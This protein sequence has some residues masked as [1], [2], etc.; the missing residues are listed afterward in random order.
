M[1]SLKTSVVGAVLAGGESR[2]LGRDKALLPWLGK[3]LLLH[4]FEVLQ[5]VMSEV[6]V[7]TVGGRSYGELGVPVIHDR[8]EGLGPLAGIHAALEWARSRPVFVV[9]CDLPFVSV[10]LVE[11]VADWSTEQKPRASAGDEAWA[12]PRARVAVW[13]G[14]QQPLC[15]LYSASCREPLEERLRDGRLEAWRFLAEI[16][17]ASIPITHDLAFYRPDLLVNIN[18]PRDLQQGIPAVA[19]EVSSS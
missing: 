13:K 19:S 3:A 9:A 1:P 16:E 14:R 6:V 8:F 12:H 15:G 11:H 5:E 7:V 10:D 4:P 18:S 2:R 17:T